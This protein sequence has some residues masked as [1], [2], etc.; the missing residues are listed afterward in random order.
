MASLT[1]EQLKQYPSHSSLWESNELIFVKH[2]Q[3]YKNIL[4][5]IISSNLIFKNNLHFHMKKSEA[6]LNKR[7]YDLMTQTSQ[8]HSVMSDS[9]WPHGLY[10]PRNS[11]G[12][13]TG[14]GIAFPFSRGS[15]QP[16]DWTQVSLIAGR[17]F[18]SWATRGAQ[19]HW[20]GE[21]IPSPGDLP[22]PV[23]EPGS[24][25]LQA[26]S[27]PTELWRKPKQPELKLGSLNSLNSVFCI[28]IK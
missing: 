14:V 4:S 5:E 10:S 22:D 3:E 28:C 18:T 25:A 17:F 15:S 6:H 26:D 20:N 12:Q 2:L 1:S 11:P 7:S 21:P 27:L 23:I 8:S 9:L 16:K 19:V 13:N 24:P